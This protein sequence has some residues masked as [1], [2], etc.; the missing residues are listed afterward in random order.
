MDEKTEASDPRK[1]GLAFVV[2]GAERI[3]TLVQELLDFSREETYRLEPLPL[4]QIIREVVDLECFG[5]EKVPQM[6]ILPG[7]QVMADR[8]KLQRVLRNGLRNALEAMDGDPSFLLKAGPKGKWVEIRIED[9]GPG[10]LVPDPKG[11]YLSMENCGKGFAK[12]L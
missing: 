2:Q 6:E 10:L 5:K 4:D 3:E 8:E 7:L 11:L 1:S 9:S 12:S